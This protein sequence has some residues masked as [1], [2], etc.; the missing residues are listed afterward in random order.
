MRL[1]IPCPDNPFQMCW[2]VFL[3]I[4]TIPLY[5]KGRLLL[6][7]KGGLLSKN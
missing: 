7:W 3:A 2:A 6:V 4:L 5:D 1:T